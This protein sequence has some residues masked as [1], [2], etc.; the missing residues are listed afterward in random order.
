VAQVPDQT[1]LDQIDLKTHSVLNVRETEQAA[2][3]EAKVRDF[4]EGGCNV[5]LTGLIG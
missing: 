3:R 5:W 1:N 4:E 2:E